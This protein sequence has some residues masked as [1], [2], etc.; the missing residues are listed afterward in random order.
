M[1]TL[2]RVIPVPKWM[3]MQV[4]TAPDPE[5][6]PDRKTGQTGEVPGSRRVEPATGSGINWAGL[7]SRLETRQSMMMSI[8]PLMTPLLD[9]Q[10]DAQRLEKRAVRAPIW[11][12][13][14]NM[15]KNRS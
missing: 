11:K 4:M 13:C 9:A 10:L 3:G 2:V 1:V 5:T 7:S 14:E 15:L 12:H 8:Q 6:D